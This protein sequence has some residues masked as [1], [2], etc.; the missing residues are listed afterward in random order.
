MA[1]YFCIQCIT[2]IQV[3]NLTIGEAT[4]QVLDYLNV[5]L[6]TGPEAGDFLQSQLSA[7]IVALE[8][9]MATFACYCS[10]RGQVLGLLLVSRSEDGFQVIGSRYLLPS[11]LKRL[12]MFVFRARVEF[13]LDDE[14]CVYG[15]LPEDKELAGNIIRPEGIDLAYLLAKPGVP[16]VVGKQS[17]PEIE[18]QHQVVWL[19]NETT[20]KFIPQML[21]FDQIGAV[22][23][24]KGCY[25]GQEIVARARYLGKVKRKPVIVS[26]EEN[27]LIP[28]AERVTLRKDSQWLNG[29]VVDSAAG[30]GGGTHLFIVAPAE[31]ESVVAE[32]KYQDHAYRCATTWQTQPGSASPV[33]AGSYMPSPSLFSSSVPSQ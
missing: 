24:T 13:S 17:F 1:E 11:I 3:K 7:D 5:A 10:V 31:P 2:L 21:G 12:Q 16:P 4:M 33:S 23:Y 8:P 18:I 30:A 19:N 32:I 22:S 20:E 28:A 9:G 26:I 29:T 25:P 15:V 6:F 27:L 14:T